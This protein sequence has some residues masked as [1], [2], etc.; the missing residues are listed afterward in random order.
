MD[1]YFLFTRHTYDAEYFLN[2]VYKQSH[3][4]RSWIGKEYTEFLQV[5]GE[6]IENMGFR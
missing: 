3:L 1:L 6:V 5:G 2:T 4:V